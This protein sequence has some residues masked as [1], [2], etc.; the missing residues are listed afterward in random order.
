MKQNAEIDSSIISTGNIFQAQKPAPVGRCDLSG[1]S[2]KRSQSMTE[3]DKAAVAK[4][5]GLTK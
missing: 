1:E 2:Q 5:F 4:R 3:E